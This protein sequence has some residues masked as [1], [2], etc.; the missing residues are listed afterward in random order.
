MALGLQSE[1][2]IIAYIYIAYSIYLYAM[3]FSL[4]SSH[5]QW[6]PS[7]NR[8]PPG[9]RVLPSASRGTPRPRGWSPG[10][11]PATF[12]WRQCHLQHSIEDNI[13]CKIRFQFLS[14]LIPLFLSNDVSPQCRLCP[15]ELFSE[16]GTLLP[17]YRD[18]IKHVYKVLCGKIKRHIFFLVS[19]VLFGLS[20]KWTMDPNVI[21]HWKEN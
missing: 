10:W 20:L 7:R 9:T 3:T 16:L 4:K 11:S 21:G 1:W 6:Q 8:A 18:W 15:K 12:D 5:Q 14:T 13:T 19:K 17:R 2:K